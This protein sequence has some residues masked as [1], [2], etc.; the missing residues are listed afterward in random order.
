MPSSIGREDAERRKPRRAPF[1]R[2]FPYRG[3]EPVP[4]R[5]DTQSRRPRTVPGDEG[6][7]G[8]V[9]H[10]E[11]I[12]ILLDAVTEEPQ[13][14]RPAPDQRRQAEEHVSRCSDCWRALSLLHERATGERP[15]HA[16][17]MRELFGCERV[18]DE[19]YLLVGLTG[20]QIAAERPG[21]AR[22]LA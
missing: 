5:S 7:A 2:S 17:R 18:Q 20:P 11:S 6:D 1:L 14:D 12:A 22:H 8:P 13:G 21:V 9:N 16:D 19:M 4:G 10:D 15:P 3:P